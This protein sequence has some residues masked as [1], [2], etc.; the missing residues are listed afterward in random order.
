MNI[1]YQERYSDIACVKNS[2]LPTEKNISNIRIE[3]RIA[4]K[5]FAIKC[6]FVYQYGG[7]S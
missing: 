5:V 2:N 3:G 6:Q 1:R 4:E 7:E